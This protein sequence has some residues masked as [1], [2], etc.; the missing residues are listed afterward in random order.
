MSK[1]KYILVAASKGSYDRPI[2]IDNVKF[3]ESKL[4][5][6]EEI[7]KWIWAVDIQDKLDNIIKLKET[8]VEDKHGN[9]HSF[10]YDEDGILIFYSTGCPSTNEYDGH[11]CQVIE[12]KEEIV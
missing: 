5:A 8:H 7:K 1:V 9:Y 11:S 10:K 4:L 3:F 12:I 6:S 2:E